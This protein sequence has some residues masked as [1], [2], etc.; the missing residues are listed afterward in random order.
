MTNLKDLSTNQ[1]QRIIA[2]KEAIEG[3][4]GQI[5]SIMD[6]RDGE[7]AEI[8]VDELPK[9]RRMSASARAKIAAAQRARWARV[10]GTTA[11]PKATNKK[12]GRSS[13]A[14]RAKMAAAARARW[15]KAKAAGKKTL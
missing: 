4:E 11:M 8:P 2:L 3:L 1:L 15:K 5:A 7:I 10:K 14:F 13:P 12:D 9:K 6:G